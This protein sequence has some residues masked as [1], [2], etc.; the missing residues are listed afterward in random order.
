MHCSRTKPG[1]E[2]RTAYG[3]ITFPAGK[4]D[5]IGIDMTGRASVTREFPP[6]GSRP[7]WTNGL[8]QAP[9]LLSVTDKQTGYTKLKVLKG[10]SP[11][12]VEEMVKQ[13]LHD[14]GI[15]GCVREVWTDKEKFEAKQQIRK[16]KEHLKNYSAFKDERNNFVFDACQF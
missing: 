10:L 11:E 13:M 7:K 14:M 9:C 8:L 2:H 5:I 15:A 12:E 3:P 1:R 6:E 4:G 16:K